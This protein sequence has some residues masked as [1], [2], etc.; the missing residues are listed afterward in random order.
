MMSILT[1]TSLVQY[2][3]LVFSKERYVLCSGVDKTEPIEGKVFGD[4]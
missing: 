1:I 4:E 3:F 2:S